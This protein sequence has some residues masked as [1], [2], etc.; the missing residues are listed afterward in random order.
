MHPRTTFLIGKRDE[1]SSGGNQHK[2]ARNEHVVLRA[3]ELAKHE[4][5]PQRGHKARAN[6]AVMRVEGKGVS[7]RACVRVCW[8]SAR[9]R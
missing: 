2:G 8:G 4:N 7:S 3:L 9:T 5:A 6:A 1:G